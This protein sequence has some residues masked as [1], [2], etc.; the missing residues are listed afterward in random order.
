MFPNP[1]DLL[2]LPQHP[3]LEQ[4]KKLAKELLRAAKSADPGAIRNW[5]TNWVK[6]LVER[7][8]LQITP[9]LPV[10]TDDWIRDVANFAQAELSEESKLSNAHFVIARSHGFASWPKLVSH[11]HSA[12]G[13]DSPEARFE[14]AADAIVTGDAPTLKELLRENPGLVRQRSTREHR[15]TLL[16]YCSANGVEGYRQKTPKNIVE[17]TRILL[18]AGA[19]VDAGADVYGGDSTTLGLA[20]TS[21]H[22]EK[23]GVQ[24]ELMQLL[25]DHGAVMD[26]SGITGGRH[27]LIRG[28][29]A[30]GRPRAARWLAERGAKLDLEGAAG[31][32]RLDA[33][34]TFFDSNGDLKPPASREDLQRGFVWACGYGYEEVVEFLLSRG[35]SLKDDAGSGQPPL[36]MAVAGARVPIVKLLIARGAPLEQVNA[37]GG[38]PLGQAGWSFVNGDPDDDYVPIFDALFAAGAHMED[39]WLGWL[40]KQKGRTP[41]QKARIADVLRRYG[42]KS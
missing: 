25:L 3:D 20:A 36:H 38:T 17:I 33:V 11:I 32:G 31:T 27:S 15:A 28:C 18:E 16:H 19:E 10:R 42:A 21:V 26:K 14:T 41:E 9:G 8:G 22:P 34:K 23:A 5:S 6:G 30:N 12:T 39:G 4:Y 1:Q 35:A 2:P 29:L 40:D 24:E 7:S 13:A 37:Y